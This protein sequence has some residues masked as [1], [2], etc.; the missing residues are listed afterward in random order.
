MRSGLVITIV[1]VF[2]L[3]TVSS[4]QSQDLTGC[5][6][7]L[8]NNYDPDATINDGSCTYDPITISPQQT[9]SLDEQVKGT[10]GLI[11]WD[12]N[13]WTHN[14]YGDPIIY[15]LDTT[16]AEIKRTYILGGTMTTNWEEISQD[17]DNIYI[18]DFGNNRGS[19]T[20]LH[21]LRVDKNTLITGNPVIDTIWFSYS[22]QAVIGNGEANQTD[23]DCEAM[24]VSEDSIYLF[25]KQW[26]S[27][28]TSVYSL[29]K[30]PGSFTALKK[31]EYDVQGLIT[32]ATYLESEQLMVLCGYSG[33]LYPF[34]ILLYDFPAHDFFSGNIRKIM[35]SLPLHQIEGIASANGLKY[36]ISNESFSLQEVI[37]T[38]QKLHIFDI[39]PFLEKY[40]NSKT[41]VISEKQVHETISFYP[42]PVKLLFVNINQ[43]FTPAVFKIYDQM[44]RL[45]KEGT[46]EDESLEL[47]M[48]HFAPGLFTITIGE[49]SR[50]VF[51]ILKH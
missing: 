15:G 1:E 22:D 5:T 28:Q 45:I 47:D 7:P 31:T 37:S 6:D 9:F 46:L 11:L 40:L 50:R 29:P 17:R 44:S 34:L 4:C 38:P 43:E 35:V 10:S 20:D 24:I 3:C 2:L 19:R 30:I 12:G 32:G 27:S 25:T 49:D 16:E 26:I 23:F 13:L 36:Y 33:L 41:S 18:G 14:D 51:K 42:N 21:I 8:A 48:S 39:S